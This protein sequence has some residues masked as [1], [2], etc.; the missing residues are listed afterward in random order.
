LQLDLK[1]LLKTLPV[2]LNGKNAEGIYR[3]K[4]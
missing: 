2:V 1:I 3:K 4:S